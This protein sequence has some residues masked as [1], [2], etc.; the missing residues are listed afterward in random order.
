MGVWY[1]LY[2]PHLPHPHPHPPSKHFINSNRVSV[3]RTKII[4]KNIKI[5]HFY[6]AIHDILVQGICSKDRGDINERWEGWGWGWGIRGQG[7]LNIFIL[8]T[9]FL[10]IIHSKLKTKIISFSLA[11]SKSNYM[12][13]IHPK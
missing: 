7:C 11:N 13:C 12:T 1:T 5:H 2:T 10:Y 3:Q 8:L 6:T 4:K 9:V